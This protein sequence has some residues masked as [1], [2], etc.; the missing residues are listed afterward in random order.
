VTCQVGDPV[1]DSATAGSKQVA[2]AWQALTQLPAEYASYQFGLYYDQAGKAQAIVDLP[3]HTGSYTDTALSNGQQYCYKLTAKITAVDGCTAESG[4]SNVVCATPS[5]AGQAVIGVT[6][7]LQTGRWVSSGKGRNATSTFELTDAF[8][9]GDAVVIQGVVGTGESTPSGAVVRV[10]I[11]RA[12]TP[13][14]TLEPATTDSTG[15]FEV[16]WQTQKP[17]KKGQGG[18]P[19][20]SYSTAVTDITLSGYSWDGQAGGVSFTLQ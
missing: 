15:R 19:T 20:G 1:L 8:A 17:N 3:W 13:V 7:P 14:A 6:E 12:G 18:T 2:L 11:S 10:T 4:F 5:A 9:A 16:N